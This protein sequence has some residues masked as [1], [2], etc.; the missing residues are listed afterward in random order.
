MSEASKRPG[1]LLKFPDGF[2]WGAST[3]SHQV[4]G[5]NHNDW[6][7][8]EKANA[9]RLAAESYSEFSRVSPVWRQV[10][11]HVRD[12]E[13]YISG[14]AADHYN[15][16]E[17]DFDIAQSLNMN[18]QRISLE[19]SRIEP[20]QGKFD[21]KEIEHYRKVIRAI[22]ARG[23][24]PFVTTWHFTL[25]IWASRLGGWTTPALVDPYVRYVTKLAQEFGPDIKFWMT[26][27]EPDIYASVEWGVWPA[28]R[29]SWSKTRKVLLHMA[30][31]HIQAY[32][33]IKELDSDS[34][35]GVAKNNIH[36]DIRRHWLIDYVLRNLAESLWNRYFLNKISKHQDFIGLNH[37]FRYKHKHGVINLNAA[38]TYTSDL[39]WEIHPESIYYVLKG[40]KR[41]NKPVYITENGLADMK[42]NYRGWYIENILRSVHRAITEGVNVKGYFH[43]S[44]LDNFE[45]D[46]GFWP[47][48]GLIEV[49]RK[50]LKRTVRQSARIYAEIIDQN[51]VWPAKLPEQISE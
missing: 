40:I 41:Y 9:H 43:W 42:D 1:Y 50:T 30:E 12:P 35:I 27:N 39:G 14:V 31:A 22:K 19:W 37:Y 36:F 33:R 34:Q 11:P 48:F 28:K 24:E 5:N 21:Q 47:R 3:S 26:H 18:A 20:E 44:L 32:R 7:E 23:M 10:E 8:W 25:P 46:K 13:N 45:W 16:Y 49:D 17:E 51:G 38:H 15:R 2:L 4:E 29:H 6:T